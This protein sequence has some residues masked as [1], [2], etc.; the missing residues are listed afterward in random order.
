MVQPNSIYQ[1]FTTPL[2]NIKILCCKFSIHT[3]ES[4]KLFTLGFFLINFTVLTTYI[5]VA[6]RAYRNYEQRKKSLHKTMKL[7]AT[8]AMIVSRMRKAIAVPKKLAQSPFRSPH[9]SLKS[10]RRVSSVFISDSY[11]TVRNLF[12]R[13]TSPA[14]NRNHLDPNL[15]EYKHAYEPSLSSERSDNRQDIK[16]SVMSSPQPTRSDKKTTASVF[17][18]ASNKK[19]NDPLSYSYYR[20]STPVRQARMKMISSPRSSYDLHQPTT[21]RNETKLQKIN[22]NALKIGLVLDSPLS[23]L[24]TYSV[25]SQ[26]SETF[27]SQIVIDYCS[28]NSLSDLPSMSESPNQFF[29]TPTR[30]LRRVSADEFYGSGSLYD[31][32]RRAESVLNCKSRI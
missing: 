13:Q 24:N 9:L 23:F 19:A 1:Q 22:H 25:T 20:N 11:K 8:S 15:M 3:P 29:L 31:R 17:R 16:M 30:V 2:Q 10:S 5:C 27:N 4:R 12:S 14:L 26:V 32:T 7:A 6:F 28:S 18:S 21:K